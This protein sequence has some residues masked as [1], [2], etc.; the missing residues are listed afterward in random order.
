MENK[1]DFIDKAVEKA[2]KKVIYRWTMKR[3]KVNIKKAKRKMQR[4]N[5]RKGRR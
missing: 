3:K 5:R 4:I 1:E 2:Y